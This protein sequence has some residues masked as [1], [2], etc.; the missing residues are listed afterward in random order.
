M[1]KLNRVLKSYRD[2]G[3]LHAS[4]GIQE[5]VDDHTFLTKG[6]HLVRLLRVHGIDDECLDPQQ[7]DQIASRIEA[8]L[9]LLG[10]NFRL[11]CS[12]KNPCGGILHERSC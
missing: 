7:V 4:I 5:A 6:G 11:L 9:R 2:S 10:E 8:A 3:A 1:F 12:A